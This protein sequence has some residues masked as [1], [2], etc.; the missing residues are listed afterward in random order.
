MQRAPPPSTTRG[1]R[2]GWLSSWV[3]SLRLAALSF[4]SCYLLEMRR[5]RYF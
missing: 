4:H 1:L 2:W 5:K 3:S